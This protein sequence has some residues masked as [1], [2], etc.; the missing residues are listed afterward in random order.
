MPLKIVIL[1]PPLRQKGSFYPPLGALS[2]INSTEEDGHKAYLVDLDANRCAYN[3]AVE[4]IALL[5]PDVIGI[6]AVVSTSYKYVKVFSLLV[7]KR[8]PK[9]IIIV[10]GGL[11]A[12][13]DTILNNTSVD[14]I[15]H[16]E[17][18]ITFKELLRKIE[19]NSAYDDVN[20]VSFKQNDN[21]FKTPARKLI[22]NLDILPFPDYDRIDLN[23]YILN[24]SQFIKDYGCSEENIK[25]LIDPK[26]SPRFMRISISR[27][28]VNRCT[29]CYRHMPG[30]RIHSFEYIGN[31]IEYVK[32]K[33]N[34]GHISF[35]D[36]CFGPS[37]QWL[38][39]FINMM[40]SRKFD[41][42]FHVTGMRVNTVD[43]DILKALKEIGVW[44]IQFGFESGSQK[45]LDIMEKNA[46]VQENVR[47]VEM[48]RQV[49]I[50][51]IP[52]III[53][54]PGETTE[55]IYETIDFLK[56]AHLLSRVFR[57]TFPMAMPG[58]LLFE[59]AKLKGYITD[60]DTYLEAISDIEAENLSPKNY[61]INYTGSSDEVVMGWMTLLQN[62]NIKY[63]DSRPLIALL[64][65]TVAVFKQRGLLKTIGFIFQ[66]S[67]TK[68]KAEYFRKTFRNNG[69]TEIYASKSSN[70]TLNISEI[71]P[72]GESLRKVIQRI[73]KSAE[74]RSE[75][76]DSR[77]KSYNLS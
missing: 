21:I 5:S 12:A 30:L 24:M 50:N 32:T 9:V 73:K 75:W 65:K 31:L 17:G 64:R 29:F 2:I 35:G 4:R 16:G 54:Y 55:T 57:P 71:S 72:E 42:T 70:Q 13:G 36:E 19:Q 47:V 52:F 56:K 10:G 43:L 15:V 66:R 20:G 68:A 1:V 23:K 33:Y 8:L 51:S 25:I 67:F 3:E 53:G 39:G 14:I 6:S 49:G 27:G 45:I 18:E 48:V 74:D 61:F 58:T 62:E 7:K 77:N 37:K 38:W 40:R 41:L 26:R 69:K 76:F 28:C 59:Y 44:H 11:A 22:S 63:A 34:I 46:T 60:E